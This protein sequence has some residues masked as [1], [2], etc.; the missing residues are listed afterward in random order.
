[1]YDGPSSLGGHPFLNKRVGRVPPFSVGEKENIAISSIFVH[2]WVTNATRMLKNRFKQA[3]WDQFELILGLFCDFSPFL[4][5]LAD[6][7]S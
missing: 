3:V 4:L 2:L 7:S 5:V 6:F 1:M